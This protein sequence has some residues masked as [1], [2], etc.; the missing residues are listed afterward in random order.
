LKQQKNKYQSPA[1]NAFIYALKSP[2]SQEQYPAILKQFFNYLSLSGTIDEQAEA[3]IKKSKSNEV[4]WAQNSIIDFV[5]HNKKR[6]DNKDL[7]AGTL[8]N[9]VTVIKLF[10]EMNDDDIVSG[11]IKWNKISR[12]LPK[13]K[14]N[15]N[16]RSPTKKEIRKLLEYPD[17]RIKPIVLVMCSSG[18]RLGAWDNLSWKHVEPKNNNKGQVIAAKL[19]VYAGDAEEYYTF[20]TPEAYD[21]LKNYMDFRASL[22]EPI[23]D[24]SPLIRDKLPESDAKQQHDNDNDNDD[25]D[26][27]SDGSSGSSGNGAGGSS[28]FITKP[29]RL[30]TDGI[31]KILIR[32]LWAQGLRK[33][34]PNGVRRHDFKTAHGFRKFFETSIEETEGVEIKPINVA[35]LMN[36]RS[37][38]AQHYRRPVVKQVLKDYLKFVDSLTIYD[39]KIILQKQVAKTTLNETK[40]L[41][42]TV[43]QMAVR[44][45]AIESV[46]RKIIA[47]EQD[48]N[49]ND[50]HEKK[51]IEETFQHIIAPNS[52]FFGE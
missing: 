35:R 5:N 49:P 46:L 6:I 7:A 32:A 36:H 37:G 50:P 22:G 47:D 11:T 12:G 28:G 34:F 45:S 3:F 17:R 15:A 4:Q 44:Q 41:K 26:D 20:M 30:G 52:D 14:S 31:K 51:R 40:S 23:N 8:K 24:D 19:T 48:W 16:D 39:D 13:A 21:A 2:D 43:A 38:I 1:L 42:K 18:I 29:K 10:C 25:N 33:P 27:D 9:Y